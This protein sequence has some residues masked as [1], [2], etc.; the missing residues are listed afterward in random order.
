MTTSIC[1]LLVMWWIG[2]CEL[3]GVGVVWGSNV[4]RMWVDCGSIVGRLWVDC[5]FIDDCALQWRSRVFGV[6][7]E[8]IRI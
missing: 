5:G 6:L 1:V 8:N 3:M 4:G 2:G 7:T